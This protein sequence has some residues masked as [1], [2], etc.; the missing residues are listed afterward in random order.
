MKPIIGHTS[1]QQTLTSMVAENALP[2]ALLFHG[3]QGI[4]KRL[5]AEKLVYHLF[6][7][8]ENSMLAEP[9]GVDTQHILY[10]QLQELSHPDYHILQPE[11][12][13]KVIRIPQVRELINQ[14]HLS[15]DG[16]KVVIIDAAEQMNNSA[17]NAL[18]KTLEEP[19]EDIHIILICHNLSK[20]LPTIISRCRKFRFNPLS[21]EE[22]T[23][24]LTQEKAKIDVNKYI[25]FTAGSPGAIIHMV[26]EG[27]EAL[28]A[29]ETFFQADHG[30]N[31]SEINQIAEKLH[32]KKQ[33]GI[34]LS[35]LM[36]YISNQFKQD[37]NPVWSEVYN[38][39][40]HKQQNMAEFNLNPQLTLEAALTDVTMMYK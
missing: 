35:I 1:I 39:I 16:K 7:P 13:K 11:E 30:M 38:K 20:L 12:G 9:L 15:A 4:G 31:G 2:H 21:K 40:Q 8:D 3:S 27:K 29:L 24:V 22:I 36:T 17:A 18:L 28:N 19:G 26:Q 14:L 10:P 25:H 33:A 34:A 5:V 23:E 37:K 32:R 6:C